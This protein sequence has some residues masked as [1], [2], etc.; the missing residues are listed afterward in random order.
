MREKAWDKNWHIAIY[1]DAIRTRQKYGEHEYAEFHPNI[2]SFSADGI[3][4]QSRHL[5][6]VEKQL[7]QV[8][9]PLEYTDTENAI[10]MHK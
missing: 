5:G 1:I 6:F 8:A 7:E 4:Q 9:P 2:R 3:L 10:P